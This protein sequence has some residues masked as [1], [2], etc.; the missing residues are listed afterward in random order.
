M[1]ER[2]RERAFVLRLLEK[3]APS[4]PWEAELGRPFWWAR[5]LLFSA[6]AGVTLGVIGF[7]SGELLICLFDWTAMVVF[8]AA[9]A[10]LGGP[11]LV[12]L[13]R[14]LG[15]P[16]GLSIALAVLLTAVP[17]SAFAAAFGHFAWP[18]A[19]GGLTP[20][21]WYLKTFFVEALI[22]GL[23]T[24]TESLLRAAQPSPAPTV[25]PSAPPPTA[26][27]PPGE[28]AYCLQMQ[29]HYVRV[30]RPS[31]A[32]MELMS[33]KTA[34]ARYGAADGL[35]VHRS[36]WVARSA[37][38]AVE[39]HGRGFRLRVNGS[40]MVPVARNRIAELRAL[41]LIRE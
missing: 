41:N 5:A 40:L 12:R 14:R 39:R 31:G 28:A 15:L 30:H 13:G 20:S 34:I 19:A 22:V 37:I 18:K 10:G 35:Q 3:A 1:G 6:V 29:D 17:I 21:D 38:G 25:E 16:A 32:T 27:R 23:W 2:I 33:M 9:I 24:L 4:G 7:L 8:G 26:V 11:P 36:W